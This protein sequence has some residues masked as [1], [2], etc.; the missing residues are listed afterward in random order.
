MKSI[1]RAALKKFIL[2]T[3]LLNNTQRVSK[4]ICLH[5]QVTKNTKL[6]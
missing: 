6:H 3:H 5:H 1:A 2:P 4:T